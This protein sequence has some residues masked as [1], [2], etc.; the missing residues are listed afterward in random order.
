MTYIA[1]YP[2]IFIFI[3]VLTQLQI[4]IN[5]LMQNIDTRLT[6]DGASKINEIEKYIN[7]MLKNTVS[8]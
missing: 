7:L 8:S 1:L 5:T 3:D 6:I 4:N 2:N